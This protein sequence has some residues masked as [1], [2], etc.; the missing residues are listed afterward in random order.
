MNLILE[1]PLA[2]I[3]LEG[4]GLNREK[5]RIVEISIAI[6]Y[7]NGER[8]VKTKR[9][10]PEMPIPAEATAVHGITDADVANAPVFISIAKSLHALIDG[11][12]I[13]GYGSNSYDIPVLYHEFV[14]AGIIWDYKKVHFID[15]GIIFK[16]QE[17]RDLAAA[18]KFYCGKE[19]TGAHGAEADTLA[20]AEVFFSQ[21]EKYDLP[22]TVPEL[23]L[24]SNY[25]RK[26]LDLSGKFTYNDKDQVVYNFG[27]HRGMP[28]FAEIGFLDWML[29]KD[30]G[31][32]TISVIHDLKSQFLNG[33]PLSELNNNQTDDG[34]PF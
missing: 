10:N 25:G 16:I 29:T 9:I 13:A 3:D 24:Y 31:Q 20:T 33:S 21:M 34:L 15:A 4:T 32:D 2:F 23:A 7:P 27:P 19:H 12:D 26:I 28:V 6:Q 17:P 18:V 11:C 30:F 1:K 5:D 14:R 8:L 22:K